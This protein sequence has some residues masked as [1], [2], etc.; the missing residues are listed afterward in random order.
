MNCCNE[1]PQF[2]VEFNCGTKWNVCSNCIKLPIFFRHVSSKEK[3][4]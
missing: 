2:V 1:E 3:L 4:K